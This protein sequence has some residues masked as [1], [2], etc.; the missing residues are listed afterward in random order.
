MKDKGNDQVEILLVEDSDLDAELTM[1]ALKRNKLSNNVV[2]LKDGEQAIDYLFAKG[3]FKG[4]N[5]KRKPKLVL[6]D[7]KMPKV[8][9]LEVLKAIRK[10]EKT[11]ELPV[12]MLTSSK[13]ER[14]MVE[15]YTYGVNS[16]IVK[17]V[18]FDE[19]TKAVKDVGFYWLILNQTPQ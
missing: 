15:S 5:T 17:P 2:R 18:E 9:G 12:V 11:K 7:L 14:D 1:K 6:L 8:S 19:F 3:E 4:R 13:E 10:N 16:Y